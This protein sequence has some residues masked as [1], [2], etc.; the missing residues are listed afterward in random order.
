LD[1][2]ISKVEDLPDWSYDGSSTY[3]AATETSEVILKPVA[4]FQDPFR[5]GDNTLVMCETYVWT[6][7]TLTQLVLSNTNFRYFAKQ[8]MDKCAREVP[9][10]GIEQ[11]YTLLA[12]KTKFT[13]WPIGWPQN[14][15]PG[16]QGPYYCSVGAASCFGRIVADMH[17]KACLFAVVGIFGTNAEV[18]PG[19]WEYQVGPCV[20]IEAVDH[21]WMSRYLLQRVVED[22]NV[23]VS[24]AP[25]LFD[26]WN[27][28]GCHTN[29]SD[30]TM[31]EGTG[32][33]NYRRHDDQARS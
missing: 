10:F 17:A 13:T 29:F 2:K 5:Q 1:G 25:K 26:D 24:F 8:I 27:G 11:E 12:Q 33:M 22:F 21:L 30:K 19:Q 23:D 3:Q 20:G 7:H 31:R 9:W 15:Y 18:F 14:G 16:P 28:S 6:D 4:I 32:G